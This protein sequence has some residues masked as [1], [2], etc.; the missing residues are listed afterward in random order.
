MA[1]CEKCGAEIPEKTICP[2]CAE[3][4]NNSINNIGK[5]LVA[6]QRNKWI[7]ILLAFFFGAFGIHKF[8]LGQIGT[9]IIYLL[10]CWTGIT[11]IIGIIEAVLYL[12][13]S[14]AEFAAKYYKR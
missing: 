10:F 3:Q 11:A 7:A 14:D 12:T 6:G 9:G 2:K 13:M 8:Y 4:N 1:F 5:D